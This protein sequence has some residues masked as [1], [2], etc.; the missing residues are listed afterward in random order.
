MNVIGITEKNSR[1]NESS[2]IDTKKTKNKQTNK[3]KKVLWGIKKYWINKTVFLVNKQ[4]LYLDILYICCIYHNL[5]I[6][7]SFLGRAQVCKI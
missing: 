2:S 6:I 3:Q 1:L 5:N 7:D 4:E